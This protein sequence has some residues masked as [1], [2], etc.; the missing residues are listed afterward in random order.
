MVKTPNFLRQ[1][2][3]P[4]CTNGQTETE[5]EC[6]KC[7]G[8]GKV[9]FLFDINDAWTDVVLDFSAG[10]TTDKAKSLAKFISKSVANTALIATEATVVVADTAVKMLAKEK[11]RL[12]NE[13]KKEK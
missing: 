2:K 3:C 13:N 8:T 7:D 11:I 6:K 5:E 10:E 12:E 4:D 9:R 1:R